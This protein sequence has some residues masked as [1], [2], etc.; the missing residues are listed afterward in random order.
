LISVSADGLHP[1]PVGPVPGG[2]IAGW[3][4]LMVLLAVIV[5][6]GVVLSS[7]R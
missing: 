1:V 4:W 2:S 7:R 5:V 3:I 6:A